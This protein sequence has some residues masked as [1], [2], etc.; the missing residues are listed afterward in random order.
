MIYRYEE[1]ISQ[2]KKA[3]EWSCQNAEGVHIDLVLLIARNHMEKAHLL[4]RR[5][6]GPDYIHAM[7]N[8]ILAILEYAQAYRMC[9]RGGFYDTISDRMIFYWMASAY[10]NLGN[11][12]R[13]HTDLVYRLGS[14]VT[15]DVFFLESIE[16][17]LRPYFEA[18][19]RYFTAMA[20]HNVINF[21]MMRREHDNEPLPWELRYYIR[22]A[23]ENYAQLR[24]TSHLEKHID[25]STSNHI[26]HAL[27]GFSAYVAAYLYD[28]PN[29][30]AWI[31]R[32]YVE[33]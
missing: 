8:Y 23:Y 6:N 16:H 19:A 20:C 12:Q 27:R 32:F 5:D 29:E 30:E 14:F 28:H 2:L 17:Q 24:G 11:V 3:R 4:A 7:D 9:M 22:E 26:N 15:A 33:F 10:F 18:H 1:F 21:F 13:I 25:G 31:N